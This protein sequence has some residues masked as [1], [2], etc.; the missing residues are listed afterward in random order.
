MYVTKCLDELRLEVICLQT[1]FYLVFHENYVSSVL[2]IDNRGRELLFGRE[3]T[4]YGD[5]K[6]SEYY[7][8]IYISGKQTL[9]GK[10][11]GQEGNSPDHWLRSPSGVSVLKKVE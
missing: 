6:N 1:W 11:Q 5:S 10:V 4:L 7:N 3:L 8:Q 2:G 9:G